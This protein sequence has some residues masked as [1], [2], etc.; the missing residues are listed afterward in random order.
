MD[1]GPP[2]R[3]RARLPLP[4]LTPPL[5]LLLNFQLYDLDDLEVIKSFRSERPVNSASISPIRVSRALKGRKEVDPAACSI[6]PCAPL[7][8]SRPS[9]LFL[10]S[11]I[12]LCLAV[13]KRPWR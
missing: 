2:A 12:T 6:A 8:H 3:C 10:P 11:R 5:F 7:A 9:L 4:H 13:D 1:R